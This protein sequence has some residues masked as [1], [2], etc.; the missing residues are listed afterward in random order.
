MIRHYYRQEDLAMKK[1]VLAVSTC[2]LAFASFASACE[3][4][5]QKPEIPDPATAV[6]AQMVKSNNEVKAYVKATEDY[7]GCARMNASDLRQEESDLRAFADEFNQAI[8]EFKA[9]G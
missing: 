5:Q 3:K 9:R 8:R 6:T 7:L 4:P 2:L 1:I